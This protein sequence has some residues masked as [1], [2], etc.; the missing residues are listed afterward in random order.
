MDCLTARPRRRSSYLTLALKYENGTNPDWTLRAVTRASE[1]DLGGRGLSSGGCEQG[2]GI[3]PT[4]VDSAVPPPRWRRSRPDLVTASPTNLRRLSQIE[5]RAQ[6]CDAVEEVP[7]HVVTDR[8]EH[9]LRME[10][11]ALDGM[12][13]VAYAHHQFLVAVGL[14]SLDRRASGHFVSG[15][16]VLRGRRH[17]EAVGDLGRHQ[18]VVAPGAEPLIESRVHAPAVVGD[19]ERLAVDRLRRAA[20]RPAVGVDGGFE[21]ETDPE[22]RH[23]G[24]H[25]AEHVEGHAHVAVVLGVA[26]AGI[27]ADSD[28][29][30]E[31]EETEQKMDGVLTALE[32]IEDEPSPEPDP[33]APEVGR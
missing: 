18:R 20:D 12:L 31:Y 22:R 16:A 6:L 14:A 21:P 25:L 7:D 11:N 3:S 19:G 8:R 9:A 23:L 28:P 30:A 32:R 2:G 26:G 29:A 15:D 27:V 24:A 4:S 1:C 33:D 10:L 17:L 13:A 5:N